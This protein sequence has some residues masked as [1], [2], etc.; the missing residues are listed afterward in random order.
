MT[1]LY[2]DGAN[3]GERRVLARAAVLLADEGGRPTLSDDL[4]ALLAERARHGDGPLDIALVALEGVAASFLRLP[5]GV[6]LAAVI[7]EEAIAGAAPVRGVPLVAGVENAR[8]RIP[9][10]EI[11]IVDALRSRIIVEPD[12]VEI[13]RLQTEPARPAVLLGEHHVPAQTLGGQTVSVWAWARDFAEIAASVDHGADG[14]V[15]LAG[16]DILPP[17]DKNDIFAPP[18]LPLLIEA[19]QMRGGG[20]LA[21]WAGTDEGAPDVQTVAALAASCH[22]RW[23]LE[24]D[25]LPVPIGSVYEDLRILVHE[26]RTADR[27]ADVPLLVAVTGTLAP[28]AQA[29]VAGFDEILFTYTEAG[30]SDLTLGSL[31]A[32]P[33][34]RVFIADEADVWT[35]VEAASSSGAVGVVVPSPFVAAAKNYIR[36]LE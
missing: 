17:I 20:A 32:L 9:E 10:G 16:G 15:L 11:V 22:L 1:I 34:V 26:E 24:P 3:G 31:L 2:G 21:L 6:L 29:D 18:V 28:D 4:L 23:C 35:G 30:A 14:V 33:P 13:V 7:A 5:P 12:A 25:A 27:L 19:A 8:E 36:S